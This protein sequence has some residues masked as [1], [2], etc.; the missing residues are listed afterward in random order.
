MF[1]DASAMVAI[2]VEESDAAALTSDWHRLWSRAPHQSRSTRPSPAS[3]G[4]A[5]SRSGQQGRSSTASLSKP[6]CGLCRSPLKS[7]AGLS[8][9]SSGTEEGGTPRRSIWAIALPMLAPM[10]STCPSCSKATIF[11]RLTLPSP[12]G[13][14]Q[15]N[16]AHGRFLHQRHAF[17]PWRRLGTLSPALRVGRRDE[18]GHRRALERNGR[19]G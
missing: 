17:R 8:R 2:L 9:R 18:R 6:Q 14:A 3:H 5:T 15:Q 19:A 10:S 11:H 7:G 16:A 1:V 12:E 13:S 4:P